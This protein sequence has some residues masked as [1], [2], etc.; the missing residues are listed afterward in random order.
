MG[1][2]MHDSCRNGED[3]GLQNQRQEQEV[4][5]HAAARMAALPQTE[6]HRTTSRDR[7][8]L[9]LHMYRPAKIEG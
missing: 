2:R 7:E 4:P 9:E 3:L 6:G 5:L 1:L 8:N